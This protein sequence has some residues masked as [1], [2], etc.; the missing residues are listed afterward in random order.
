[1]FDV[2]DQII[3]IFDCISDISDQ[4]GILISKIQLQV[5]IHIKLFLF[6]EMY[7]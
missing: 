4:L 1:M 2:N 3:D 5:C 6:S 7:K